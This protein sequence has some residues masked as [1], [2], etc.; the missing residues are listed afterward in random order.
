[1]YHEA[2]GQGK[3]RLG[4]SL[5]HGGPKRALLREQ[6]FRPWL[7]AGGRKGACAAGLGSNQRGS[8]LDTMSVECLPGASVGC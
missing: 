4:H 3:L 8:D 1:M 5:Y 6:T 7:L 2:L